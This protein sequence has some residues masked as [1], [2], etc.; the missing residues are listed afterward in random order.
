MTSRGND[1]GPPGLQPERTALAWRR[2]ALGL[3][4]AGV[5]DARLILTHGSR[6]SLIPVAICL[7]LALLVTFSAERLLHGPGKNHTARSPFTLVAIA[8][9]GVVALGVSG[10]WFVVAL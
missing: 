9:G 4:A 6:W 3:V 10:L 7:A 8:A 5:L 2:F 1:S